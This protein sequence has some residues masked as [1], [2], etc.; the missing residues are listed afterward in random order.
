MGQS[1][2]L[3][4]ILDSKRQMWD[5]RSSSFQLSLLLIVHNYR[6]RLIELV[7]VRLPKEDAMA[8]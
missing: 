3:D 4:R 1:D 7:R 2:W 5:F 6:C 8:V